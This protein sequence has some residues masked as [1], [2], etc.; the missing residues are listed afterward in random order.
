[1]PNHL[2]KYQTVRHRV[3]VVI[4]IWVVYEV[5]DQKNSWAF[6]VSDTLID[7]N[8]LHRTV[9]GVN[10]ITEDRSDQSDR[11]VLCAINV[12]LLSTEKSFKTS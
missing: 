2:F 9:P 1:M 10:L 8:F 7:A 12:T 5:L 6:K 3:Q 4:V 11:Q